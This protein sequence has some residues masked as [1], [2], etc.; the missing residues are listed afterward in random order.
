[1]DLLEELQRDV[2]LGDGAMR[3]L[4]GDAP[5]GTQ[6]CIEVLCVSEP[7]SVRAVHLEY[8]K[9]G[10]RVL[11]TN[12]FGANP[13]RLAKHGLAHRVSEINWTAA[14]IARECAQGHRVFV[15]GSVGPVGPEGG[16]RSGMARAFAD[17][18][19]ALLDGGAQAIFLEKFTDLDEL[20]IALEVKQ[21]LHHCPAI[22]LVAPGS[23]DPAVYRCTVEAALTRLVEAGADIVGVDSAP[24]P[25]PLLRKIA[26]M[27][28]ETTVAMF[29]CPAVFSPELINCSSAEHFGATALE[30]QRA[31]VRL[32]GG[33]CNT[34]PAHIAA[35]AEAFAS[36]SDDQ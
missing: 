32:I 2:L 31:G 1:M 6:S 4:L 19:G 29:P 21:S 22:C 9:A 36:T 3:A 15:A 18:I 20:L 14:Q 33:G 8:I 16:G 13:V 7:D 26:P 35:A 28:P 24:S 17:Q 34:T 10:A 23:D 5:R 11:R 27:L 25:E 30:L 12:S